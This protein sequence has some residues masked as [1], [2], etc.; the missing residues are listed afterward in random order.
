[1]LHE[2]VHVNGLHAKNEKRRLI[3]LLA[4]D[5]VHSARYVAQEDHL[6]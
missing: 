1:M 6:L 5:Y 4:K 3:S 2:S